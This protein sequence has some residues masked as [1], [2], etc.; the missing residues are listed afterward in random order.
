M[1]NSLFKVP[2]SVDLA[3]EV[4][5]LAPTEV[6]SQAETEVV[7]RAEVED[8]QVDLASE[9]VSLAQTEVD[10]RAE[11]EDSLQVAPLSAAAVDPL[12]CRR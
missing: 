6:D 7:S 9:V 4:D 5:S 2:D 12:S 3:S 11:T 8:S 1:V 10:S